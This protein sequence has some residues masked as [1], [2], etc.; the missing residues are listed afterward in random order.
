[1]QILVTLAEL[2]FA[3]GRRYL[4]PT[5][6]RA[7]ESLSSESKRETTPRPWTARRTALEPPP[8]QSTA[9]PGRSRPGHGVFWPRDRRAMSELAHVLA[10]AM[11]RRVS[12][13][14]LSCEDSRPMRYDLAMRSR[15]GEELLG[16][17]RGCNS[18]SLASTARPTRS[19]RQTS[20]R[21]L[22]QSP[23]PSAAPAS[24]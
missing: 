2:R 9:S 10:P 19:T 13:A 6:V 23:V 15:S 7:A 1:M 18:N 14:P 5:S 24:S 4:G 22:R 3:I 17:G 20:C 11:R 21:R 16:V 12:P 8:G